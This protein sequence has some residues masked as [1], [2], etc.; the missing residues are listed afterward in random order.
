[1]RKKQQTDSMTQFDTEMPTTSA[2]VKLSVGSVKTIG[3]Q[4]RPATTNPSR[5]NLSCDSGLASWKTS[6]VTDKISNQSFFPKS[7]EQYS[8]VFVNK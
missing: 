2:G 3:S 1:M 8:N 7:G 5:M 6:M 4:G